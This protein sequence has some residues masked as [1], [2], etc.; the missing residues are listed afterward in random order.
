MD[1]ALHYCESQIGNIRIDTHKDN[2]IMQHILESH[3]YTKCG[4]IY[5]DDGMPRIAYQKVGK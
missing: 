2:V 3:Y 4:T 5:A 1:F